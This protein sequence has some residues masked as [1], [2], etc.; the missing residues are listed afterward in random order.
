MRTLRCRVAING[1]R[2]A[3]KPASAGFFMPA[4]DKSYNP[5]AH[6]FAYIHTH[7]NHQYFLKYVF[8]NHFQVRVQH[9]IPRLSS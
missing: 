2:Y 4:A 1:D 7:Y 3:L 9:E 5:L 8:K 6:I